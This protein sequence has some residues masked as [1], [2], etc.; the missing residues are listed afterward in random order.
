MPK[1]RTWLLDPHVL[2]E[3]KGGY[4]LILG[5]AKEPGDRTENAEVRAR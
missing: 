2:N 3:R 1:L 4:G 5:T